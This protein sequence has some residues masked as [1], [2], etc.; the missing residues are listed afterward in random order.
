MGTLWFGLKTFS[1]SLVHAKFL[2]V[3]GQMS[4][5]FACQAAF[6]V[7]HCMKLLISFQV[8]NL[9]DVFKQVLPVW[10]TF[11]GIDTRMGG[12]HIPFFKIGCYAV[13]NERNYDPTPWSCGSQLV[14]LT[15]IFALKIE[16]NSYLGETSSMLWPFA[17]RTFL[18]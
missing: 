13:I 1:S 4:C 18:E 9:Y 7:F 6:Y 15:F 10:R 14:I 11:R 2:V 3:S 5:Q 12:R 16:L 8:N 17:S